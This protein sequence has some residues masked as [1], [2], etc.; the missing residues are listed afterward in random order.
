MASETDFNYALALGAINLI[1]GEGGGN[2]VIALTTTET[3]SETF[4]HEIKGVF[5][6]DFASH[7]E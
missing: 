7:L 5:T 3:S 2:L 6:D 1:A 4:T